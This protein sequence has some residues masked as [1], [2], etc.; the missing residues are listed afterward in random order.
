M[1]QDPR[2]TEQALREIHVLPFQIAQLK[3]APWAY[4]A[5]YNRVNGTH[6][7]E[8]YDLLQGI[9]RDEWEFDGFITSDWLVLLSR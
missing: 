1:S 4:M 2:L 3:A 7:S 9:I 8:T 5:S 6:V